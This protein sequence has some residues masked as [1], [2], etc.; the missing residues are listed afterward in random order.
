MAD[1]K[2][3]QEDWVGRRGPRRVGFVEVVEQDL[4]ARRLQ[5]RSVAGLASDSLIKNQILTAPRFPSALTDTLPLGWYTVR[6]PIKPFH[7]LSSSSGLTIYPSPYAITD[8]ESPSMLLRR[9]DAFVGTWETVVDFTPGR[10]GEEAGTVVWWSKW[11][12]SSVGVRGIEGG[13]EVV[14]K[15]PTLEDD[16]IQVSENASIVSAAEDRVTYTDIPCG[17][18]RRKSSL[19][20]M[21]VPSSF[22]SKQHPPFTH[23]PFPK[24]LATRNRMRCPGPQRAPSLPPSWSANG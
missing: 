4:V 12:F 13:R 14:F 3:P 19:R 21:T 22:V 17:C 1:L 9:Q 11:A 8:D 5:Y 23:Y 20:P 16:K 2:R 6:T 7:S 24:P 10:P 15:F 18:S